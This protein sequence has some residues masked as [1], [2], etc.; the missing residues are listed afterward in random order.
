[1]RF[2]R[3]RPI[4]E[5]RLALALAALAVTTPAACQTGSAP[6]PEP[7]EATQGVIVVG[8]REFAN[9]PD[10]DGEAARPMLMVDEPGTGRM[11]VND[12]RGPLHAVDYDGTLHLYL[13]INDPRW[14]FPV[15]YS[16]RER[17]FQSFALHPQFGEPGT[18]GYGKLYTWA[19][20]ENRAPTPD[21]VPGGGDDSHDTVLLEWTA[22]DPS[23]A[24]F[25]GDPPRELM[26]LEQPFANHNA[27]HMAFN[28]LAGPG[29]PDY[30]MLYVGVADG[31]SGG[32]PLDLAQNL[33]SIFGKILRIDP[34]G[35]N[36]A[37][38]AYG[39]P[40]D[41]PYAGRG[42][43]LGEI[44]VSGVRNPQRFG[45]DPDNG[46][47]FVADIGQNLIE[48]LSLAWSGADLGWNSWE[49]SYR[50]ISRRELDMSNP[51]G[52]PGLSYP[53][54]EYD[55]ADPLLI[56]RAAITGVV[57]YRSDAIPQ[58]TGRLLFADYPS[59]EIF[60][61][62]ADDLPEGG[63]DAIRRVLLRDGGTQR[64]F[65]ELIQAKN[66]EQGREPASRTDLRFATGPDGR[67]FLL[68]KHDG[69]IREI[70]R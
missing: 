27:G 33:G 22:R 6:F 5:T 20:T 14:S 70:V 46:N 57:A 68:N 53:I 69:V 12:M 54:A 32:D 29:D 35:S 4:T 2:H 67:L 39:I 36:S 42:D 3:P 62:S 45:W 48:E 34:L 8:V 25:D 23:A 47:L 18:P 41:N 10:S 61:V 59:G 56:G 1:M 26:R 11:F 43:A 60:H 58:L 21:F 24:T 15:Q 65:L 55:H 66:R 30:G 31:G 44:F 52:D 16:G 17:G 9:I 40:Q 50:F 19:D 64:T 28:P 63:E 7:I 51:R 38:G 37:N 49:G 13:D